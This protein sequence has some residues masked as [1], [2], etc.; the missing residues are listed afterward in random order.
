MRS[1]FL[2]PAGTPEL[3]GPPMLG[4]RFA[5]MTHVAGFRPDLHAEATS[6]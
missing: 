1:R 6:T 2:S 5:E 3:N 4:H